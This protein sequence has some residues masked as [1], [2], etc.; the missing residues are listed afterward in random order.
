[1]YY[2]IL[3]WGDRVK[4]LTTNL[5]NGDN[6]CPICFKELGD[7]DDYKYI[8]SHMKRCYCLNK[9]EN[10]ISILPSDISAD[11]KAQIIEE[12]TNKTEIEIS[13]YLMDYLYELY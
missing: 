1:M 11:M 7:V 8:L 13:N 5:E 10:K 4:Q 9:I 3:S 12:V 6:T 2:L